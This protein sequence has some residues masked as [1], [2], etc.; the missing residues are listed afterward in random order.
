MLACSGLVSLIAAAITTNMS[1]VM[2]MI[3]MY[4][5]LLGMVYMF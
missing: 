4:Y 3:N 2:L 1:K 5:T